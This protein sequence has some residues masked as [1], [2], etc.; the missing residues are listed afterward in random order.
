VLRHVAR[1]LER[2]ARRGDL[3]ARPGGDEFV[4]AL[5]GITNPS[6]AEQIARAIIAE[7]EQ[8]IELGVVTV[9]IGASIG[10][11]FGLPEGD[12]PEAIMSRADGAM[13]SAKRAGRG[14]VCLAQ[15]PEAPQ[16]GAAA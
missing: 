9:Q 8:P 15:A 11:A 3:I 10:I 4:I 1:I 14:Q 7:I 5:V 12:S 2:N 13:Y 16:A 6:K